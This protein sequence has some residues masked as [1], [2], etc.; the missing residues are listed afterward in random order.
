MQTITPYDIIEPKVQKIPILVSVPHCGTNFPTNIK[1][2]FKSTLIQSPDDTDWFVDKLY[3]FVLELGITIIRAKFSRWVI[4]LNR[5]PESKPLYDD[6]RIITSLT[7][8]TTFLGESIYVKEFPDTEEI[9]NRKKLYYWPYYKQI[10]TI[11]EELEQQF[12]KVLLFDAHSIRQYV[13]SIYDDE[14]P[15]LVLG[16][17]NEQ[18]ANPELIYAALNSLSNSRYSLQHNDPF[19]GGHITR[20]FG[21]PSQNRHALQLEMT[22]VNYMDDDEIKYDDNRAKKMQQVLTQMFISLRDAL[23]K[24]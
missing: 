5:D 9:E 8:T 21:R 23:D 10:D 22:K 7:P 20:Y 2:D 6:G 24:I 12:G 4:D 11:L 13:P 18:S 1:N 16:D 19:K 15:D 3:E 17:N 14:F